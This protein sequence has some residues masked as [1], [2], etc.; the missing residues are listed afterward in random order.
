MNDQLVRVVAAVISDGSR[1]LVCRRPPEKRHGGLW[2]FPGGKCEPGE[3]DLQALH[4]ELR[5]ELGVE[6]TS[7][8]KAEFEIHD[9]G[10]SFLIAF[11]AAQI[12][13]TVECLEHSEL[14]WATIGELERFP[15][16]PSDRRYVDNLRHASG[17]RRSR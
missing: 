11:V 14:A 13:G 1:L 5:E 16:A 6:V 15:L 10:S 7:C 3:T 2:E 9:K 12:A 8:S 4:R 17:G